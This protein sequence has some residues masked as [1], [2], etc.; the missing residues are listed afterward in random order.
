MNTAYVDSNAAD[1]VRRRHLFEGQIFVFSP[2]D[3]SLALTQHARQMI[4]DAFGDIDP[5]RAQYEMPVERYVEICAPLK[6]A[7]IHNDTTKRLIMT[8]SR[9]SAATSIG[10][11]RTFRGSAWSRATATSHPVSA[12]PIMPIVTR[13]TRR[14]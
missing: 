12:M 1:D 8:S 5:L 3:S 14:R 2:R 4:E 13:G 11:I 10:P 7:F 6:P 9:T